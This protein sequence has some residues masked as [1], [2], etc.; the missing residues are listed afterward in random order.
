MVTGARGN[1]IICTPCIPLTAYKI[2]I[3]NRISLKFCHNEV[4]FNNKVSVQR[5]SIVSKGSKQLLKAA[6]TYVKA[7]RHG[8]NGSC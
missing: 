6:D 7:L 1:P 4:L 5:H 2:I 3:N 8:G